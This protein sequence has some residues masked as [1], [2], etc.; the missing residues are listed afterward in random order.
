[1]EQP[2][3][4]KTCTYQLDSTP[5]QA[6]ALERALWRCRDRYHTAR[7]QRRTWW[8]R[9]Q[10]IGATSYRQQAER[11]DL[12]AACPGLAAGHAQV[13]QDVLLRVARTIQA[14]FR[15]VQAGETPGSPRLRGTWPLDELHLSPG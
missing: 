15:R 4:R 8:G 14:F 3:V 5:A 7:E 2:T 1:M 13:L 11:P 6:Q 9:G 10:G 12:K